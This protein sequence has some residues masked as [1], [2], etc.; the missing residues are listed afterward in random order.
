MT[1]FLSGIYL[2]P[3]TKKAMYTG[4]KHAAGAS[5]ISFMSDETVRNTMNQMREAWL[6][7]NEIGTHFN[8]HFCGSDGGSASW[9]P[10]EWKSEIEQA[11]SLRQELEDQHRLHR[12][13]A[14]A[15]RL[16]RK[17]LVGGRA[18]CLE[19]QKN[20]LPAAKEMGFRYDASSAG[21][22]QVWPS[23]R[24]SG[25][26]DFPLQ[27][28]PLP[29]QPVQVACPW[30]TTS[31]TTSRSAARPRATR[32]STGSWQQE[33]PESYMAG[34]HR[35]YYGNRAPLFIGNHFE[36]WNG[37]IYMNAVEDTVDQSVCTKADVRCVSFRQ[38][39]D[40]LDAQDPAVIAKLQGL[41]VG[42]NVSDWNA[43]ITASAQ[44][45]NKPAANRSL[46]AP[47]NAVLPR[48]QD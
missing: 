19:G 6:E 34:F 41:G 8:G 15:L 28:L 35:A 23:A 37:G 4:P 46:S 25:I 2:L 9:S 16:R 42:Q 24:R 38:L 14:A 7:G 22:L 30:T 17:E 44:S 31:C 18:P 47:D 48:R 3:K 33:A 27:S 5:D 36:D 12:P 40:W 1:Y 21:G 13:A 20:L 43:I 10:A 26:W 11:E 39:T 29:G 45:P 32:P